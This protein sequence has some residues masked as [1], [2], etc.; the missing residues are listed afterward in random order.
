MKTIPSVEPI[1]ERSDGFGVEVGCIMKNAAAPKAPSMA[2]GLEAVRAA[3]TSARRDPSPTVMIGRINFF[4][5]CLSVHAL[6]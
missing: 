4:I 6:P 2:G 1:S 3:L 5:R